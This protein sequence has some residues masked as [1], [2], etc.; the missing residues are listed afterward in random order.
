[1]TWWRRGLKYLSLPASIATMLVVAGVPVWGWPLAFL[2]V[3]FVI[4]VMDT[5]FALPDQPTMS[6]DLVRNVQLFVMVITWGVTYWLIDDL[7]VALGF[8]GATAQITPV[9]FLALIL[10][11]RLAARSR[12]ERPVVF[13]IA[14]TVVAAGIASLAPLATGNPANG[15]FRLVIAGL[16]AAVV[17]LVLVAV[18]S[19]NEV[20]APDAATASTSLSETASLS[21]AARRLGVTSRD[22]LDM[23]DRGDVDAVLVD[24]RIHVPVAAFQHAHDRQSDAKRE[25]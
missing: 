10:E 8:Y 18:W 7:E 15:D 2:A 20:E 24:G 9:L 23:I 6:P 19:G 5:L 16:A 13:L 4:L 11:T 22:L 3:L 17:G 25:G 12:D 14:A 1:M 21:H